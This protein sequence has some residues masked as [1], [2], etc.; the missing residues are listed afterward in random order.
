LNHHYCIS[1]YDWLNNCSNLVFLNLHDVE[2]VEKGVNELCRLKHLKHLDVS[3]CNENR[4]HFKEPIRFLEHLCLS[5]PLLDSLDISGTNL[6]N[7]RTLEC[8]IAGLTSRLPNPLKFLG[9]YNTLDACARDL[10]PA[11]CISGNSTEEQI[12]V[13]GRLYIDRVP[14]LEKVLNDLHRKVKEAELTLE[15]WKKALHLIITAMDRHTHEKHIQIS[16]SASLFYVIKSDSHKAELNPKMKKK[17]L[18][19]LLNGM[20]AHKSDLTVMRNGCIILSI[21]RIPEDI[22]FD[23]ERLVRILLYTVKEQV[24]DDD[25]FVQR[26]GIFLLNSLACQVGGVQRELVGSLGAIEEMLNFISQRLSAGICDELMETAWSTMWN[27]TDET[28][29]NCERFLKGGGMNLFLH[30]K[31]MFPEKK[32]LLRNMLGLIGNVAEVP[33]LRS[34]LMNSEFVEEFSFL[35]DSSLDG[36]EVSYNAA[37]VVAHLASDGVGAWKMQT[38]DRNMVLSRMVRAIKRWSI[39]SKRNI[40]YRSFEPIIRLLPVIHTPQCQL[41]AVWAIA[42]LTKV[43]PEKYCSLIEEE[44]GLHLIKNIL[45]NP[46]VIHL[47]TR[48]DLVNFAVQVSNNVA[49][50]KEGSVAQNSTVSTNSASS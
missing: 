34:Y 43:C 24:E 31:N 50:W 7:M 40:N 28:P 33:R 27:V 11:R 10:I 9:L 29:S 17:I 4:G 32:H 14:L 15:D 23:Y 1:N 35:L 49:A 12:L 38:P 8:G 21:F 30:C 5:L 6:A 3:H 47:D 44:G 19:T 37:G 22:L 48:E 39:H 25:S 16:G 41:W 36:I 45:Q 46:H 18:S 2:G 13:A 26:C 42:N 20:F